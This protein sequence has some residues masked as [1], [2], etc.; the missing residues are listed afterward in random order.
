MTAPPGDLKPVLAALDGLYEAVVADPEA[1]DDQAFATWVEDLHESHPQVAER[2]VAREV[3]RSIRQAQ[4]LA[5]FWAARPDR[6]HEVWRSAVDEALGGPGWA[7][8]LAIAQLA[9][10][11]SP[12]PEIFHEV[13]RRFPVVRF[14]PWLDGVDYAAWLA[15][16]DARAG[17]H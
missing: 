11:R 3:R 2:A 5:R 17:E 16:H 10:E 1:W 15:E 7:P 9:L 14:Q 6:V 8:G 4:R 13:K 12:D